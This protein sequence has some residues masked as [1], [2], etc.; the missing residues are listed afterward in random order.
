MCDQLTKAFFAKKLDTL[1]ADGL[2]STI[3]VAVSGGADSLCLTLMTY[4]WAVSKGIKVVALTVDHGL[5]AESLREAEQVRTWLQEKGI[6]HHILTWSGVKPKTRVEEK[7]R[8]ARYRLLLDWC[9]ENKVSCLFLAHQLEDQAETFFLRLIRSSGIDG[10]SAMRPVC[11]REGVF[12]VRPFL[13]VSRS[14]IQSY[15]STHYHHEWVEDPSNLDDKYE[16]VRLRKAKL[17]L[18]ELGLTP[19]SVALSAKRLTRVRDCLDTLTDSFIKKD[20]LFSN[21]GY[22]FVPKETWESLPCEIALRVLSR[23]LETIGGQTTPR[24][25][26]L[27]KIDFQNMK[28]QTLCGCEIV[29]NKK[30]F[31]VCRER[32]K[33]SPPLLIK[34]DT[35][36]HW[37]RFWV[38]VSKD[39]TVAPLKEA[40]DKTGLPAKVR[41]TVPAFYDGQT[42]LGVPSLDYYP[43]KDDINGTII[44]KVSKWKKM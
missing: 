1:C 11:V 39:V 9:H 3:A 15:L 31:Y 2:P 34:A 41:R 6:E 8:E 4:D 43:K 40:L 19:D 17:M 44:L 5:R 10:L 35:P 30:G 20:V 23:V 25:E 24:L 22:A 13:D 21:G 18:A 28:S 7:A 32:T 33:M 12:L 26:Q 27:E 38:H 37:D 14:D 16:R 29:P 42:L 36:T